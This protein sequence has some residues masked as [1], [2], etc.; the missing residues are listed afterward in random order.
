MIYF[1]K[2]WHLDPTVDTTKIEEAKK[3]PQY[4]NQFEIF[5]AIAEMVAEKNVDTAV[6]EGC[7]GEINS[8]FKDAFNGWTFEGLNQE[9]SNKKFNTILTHALLK[10]AVKFPESLKVRCG[11]SLSRI[12][13]AQL[14]LSDLR[15]DIGYWKRIVENENN[16]KKLKIYLDGINEM[17][18]LPSNTDAPTALI[19]LKKDVMS[20][21]QKFNEAN[22][23]RDAELVRAIK[24]SD[25]TKPIVV[26]Y[27]GLHSEDL[28]LKLQSEKWNCEIFEPKSY[29]NNEEKLLDEFKKII[30]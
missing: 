8:K 3:L 12:K 18:K 1:I 17:L 14:A 22:L 21:F 5:S 11:D 20:S 30:N 2:Q 10:A 7:E 26:V 19:A 25:S 24:N 29:Q 16:P 28:K 4:K 23:E 27:G 9:I 6:A 13:Y 15:G